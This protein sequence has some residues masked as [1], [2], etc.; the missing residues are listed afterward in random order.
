MNPVPLFL[1]ILTLPLLL[2]GCDRLSMIGKEPVAEAKPELEGVNQDELVLRD[3]IV[4]LKGSDTSYTGKV[5]GLYENGKKES[6]GNYKDGKFDGL[7]VLWHE[8][9]QKSDEGN[10]EDG[11]MDGLHVKWY[12]NGKKNQEVNFKDDKRDGL[13]VKWHENGQK[14]YEANFKDGKRI[15]EKYWNSKS[16]SVDSIEEA[17]AE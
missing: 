15:S 4:Y 16:Q 11:K 14:S 1:I 3:G 5:Y 10:F 6:E 9:G 12:P 8:N 2:G 13:H 7:L 17:E